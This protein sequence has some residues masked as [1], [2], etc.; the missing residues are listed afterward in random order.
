MIASTQTNHPVAAFTVTGV[1][2]PVTTEARD[3][4]C[5]KLRAAGLRSTQPRIAIY[6]V[7][8]RLT[9]PATIEQIYHAIEGSRCDLVT[10]YRGLALF[11]EMGL[12]TRTFANNGTGL[13][14]LRREGAQTYYAVCKRTG[15]REAIDA[16]H[17]AELEAVLSRIEASL[18]L[19][20]FK[21]L[22][23]HLEFSGVKESETVPASE[24]AQL[25]RRAFGEVLN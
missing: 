3:E 15:R 25:Q 24:T 22:S 11:E 16:A 2:Q 20:G 8:N 13:Y 21:G 19:R 17:V 9:E 1:R 7:L 18:S 4:I 5:A 12:V 23:H 6:K 14:Q 10:V